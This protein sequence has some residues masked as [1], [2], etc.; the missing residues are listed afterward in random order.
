MASR[1]MALYHVV[2]SGSLRGLIDVRILGQGPPIYEVEALVLF[3]GV[4]RGVAALHQHEP[5]WAHRFGSRM[6]LVDYLA[7]RFVKC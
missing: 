6:I 1:V 4:C 5:S 7:W 3:I 2:V